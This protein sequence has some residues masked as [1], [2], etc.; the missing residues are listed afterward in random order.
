MFGI[1]EVRE[2]AFKVMVVIQGLLGRC[3]DIDQ[4]FNKQHD[5]G[6]IFCN[7]TNCN[8]ALQSGIDQN[9]VDTQF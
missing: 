6:Y 8:T 2:V 3:D 5:T 4:V 9:S 7:R 1:V